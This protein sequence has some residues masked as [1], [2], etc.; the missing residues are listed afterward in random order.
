MRKRGS[1]QRAKEDELINRHKYWKLRLAGHSDLAISLALGVSTKTVTRIRQRGFQSLS[2]Y[3]DSLTVEEVAAIRKY[4]AE[5]VSVTRQ[6]AMSVQATIAA[7]V[8][9]SAEKT[10]DGLASARLL[11]AIM[12]ATAMEADLFGTKQPIRLVEDSMRLEVRKIDNKVTIV[13]DESML[14]DD[15]RDVPGLSI[16]TAPALLEAAARRNGDGNCKIADGLPKTPTN[17]FSTQGSDSS[18]G[19]GAV[20]E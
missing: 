12:R 16:R 2:S 20:S 7:R 17:D 15:G 10:A 14:K 19:D 4:Q 3:P 9:T 5:I 8:G 1:N 6:Q 11:E 18:E 13:W